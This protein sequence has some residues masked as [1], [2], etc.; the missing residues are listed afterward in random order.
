MDRLPSAQIGQAQGEQLPRDSLRSARCQHE[1]PSTNH[2]IPSG[3][4]EALIVFSQ[5]T[6]FVVKDRRWRLKTY[7][8]CFVASE[9]VDWMQANLGVSREVAVDIGQRLLQR[10]LIHHCVSEWRVFKDETLFF[11]WSTDEKRRL[12][13]VVLGGGVAGSSIAKQLDSDPGV[14]VTLVDR[15]DYFEMTP[16]VLRTIAK[17]TLEDN[18]KFVQKI[19]VKH[20]RYIKHGNIVVE[21]VREVQRDRVVLDSKTVIFDYL[22]IAT[23]SLYGSST[24]AGAP[25]PLNLI[26]FCRH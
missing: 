7:A 24:P 3:F 21:N 23:G 15:K 9:A 2:T 12:Q 26:S 8:S 14:E 20:D 16:A 1:E 25:A 22:V 11:R 19:V 13:V 4:A 18:V 10:D 17:P 5:A 6:G